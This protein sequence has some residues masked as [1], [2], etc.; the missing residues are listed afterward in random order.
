MS[1]RSWTL[2]EGDCREL[3]RG[4]PA[5]SV[6]CVVT[7]PPYHGLRAYGTCPQLWGGD[8]RCEHAFESV[9]TKRGHGSG[10]TGIASQKQTTIAGA[11]VTDTK[12][13]ATYSDTCALCGCWRGELGLEPTLDAWVAHLVEVFREVRRVLRR[14][15]TLWLNLGDS[16]ACTPNG[17]AAAEYRVEGSDDRTFRDKPF[18]TVGGTLK[19]GDL[20]GQPWELALALRRD[21]WY[22]RRDVI[23]HKPNAKPES[24]KSRPATSHEYLFQ[25]TREMDYFWDDE[26]VRE[27]ATGKPSGN[28]RR[29]L[30][31][32]YGRPDC[33][34]GAGIP[35][36]GSASRRCRSV[37]SINTQ[38]FPGAHFA[39]YPM[40]LVER[41]I[42][43]S[44]S[45][46]GCCG[47][48]RA[49]W[50]R[51]V[52]PT[53]EY[54]A[55]FGSNKGADSDRMGKGY[56]KCSPG[57]CSDYVTTGWEPSCDCNGLMA[58]APVPCVVLDPFAGSGTTLIV[59]DRLGRDAVGIE[60][61]PDY[62]ALAHAR[63]SLPDTRAEERQG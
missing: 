5:E 31:A 13:R 12:D 55:H 21:G 43:A 3:L 1:A 20:C 30:G 56:R 37:W 60:L 59:A 36:A 8:P 61:Q 41:C 50:K 46:H 45:A 42:Q 6:H 63:A 25:L 9:R 62:V 53:P 47:I 7:S 57:V 24:V 14:D 28:K 40:K 15:G 19:E 48:C 11:Y 26:A 35:H 58:G 38:G 49:P 17:K 4:M 52:E 51:T 39:T 10:G 33:H 29:K 27:P 32:E 22:L 23:W 16:Y 2:L 44:T 54:A 34:V 18:S